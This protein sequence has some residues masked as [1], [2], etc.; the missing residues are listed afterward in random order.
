M[1]PALMA[2]EYCG[3]RGVPIVRGGV[4]PYGAP[5]D[6]FCSLHVQ[7]VHVMDAL[8][9]FVRTNWCVS[10]ALVRSRWYLMAHANEFVRTSVG[11]CWFVLVRSCSFVREPL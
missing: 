6:T 2:M 7:C 4:T 3:E 10:L 11:S 1:Y 8:N 9:W 5:A